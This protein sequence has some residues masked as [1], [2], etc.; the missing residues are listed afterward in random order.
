[1][2][3]CVCLP[4]A[5]LFISVC[6]T[7]G[8]SQ[9][10]QRRH[11]GADGEEQWIRRQR[12]V[13]PLP[14]VSLLCGGRTWETGLRRQHESH[15]QRVQKSRGGC[16]LFK[17]RWQVE[18][19]SCIVLDQIKDFQIHS[20][21]SHSRRCVISTALMILASVL[22]LLL[23]YLCDFAYYCSLHHGERRAA[24]IHVPSCGGLSSAERLVPLLKTLIQSMLQQLEEPSDGQTL[25]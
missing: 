9:R 11:P 12:R 7:S 22:L 3:L 19:P 18:D 4:S 21:Q 20:T 1:M 17:R 16:D 5:C 15:R 25:E 2:F 23:R 14:R 10:L 24:L 13:R 8:H 6:R